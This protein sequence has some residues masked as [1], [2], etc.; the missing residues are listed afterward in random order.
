MSENLLLAISN[1]YKSNQRVRRNRIR[2]FAEG[3]FARAA[4]GQHALWKSLYD[5]KP[6]GPKVHSA[7][8]SYLTQRT[9][10]C[11]Y[12]Q[13]RIFHNANVNIDHILP[14]AI[15][16][17]FTFTDENLI[18]ACVTC[19]AIKSDDDFYGVATNE[20]NY[21]KHKANWGSFHPRHHLYDDHIRMIAV[22]TNYFYVRAFV[23]KTPEGSNL[24]NLF[25]NKVTDFG[26]K[27]QANAKIAQAV[28]SLENLLA[29]SGG[30]QIPAVQKL[31]ANLVANI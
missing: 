15:F 29:A 5:D 16:P 30:V 23:G 10:R 6:L 27:A 31:L 9:N 3:Y 17:Q 12:C 25:L 19:N 26:T 11:A 13:D 21:D 4:L 7:L 1:E 22:Q 18:A 2:A 28:V 24:C 14:K 8:R 20:M